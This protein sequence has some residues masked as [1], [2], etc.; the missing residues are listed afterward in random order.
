MKV[1]STFCRATGLE[2][3]HLLRF[4][5]IPRTLINRYDFKKL[6]PLWVRVDL[7]VMAMKV[8]S[9]FR[10]A[11]GLEPHHL[12]RFSFIP[13]TLIH[14][15]ILKKLL[16]LRVRVDLGVIAMK[17]C[18]ILP[19]LPKLQ[20]WSFTI[21]C[22]FVSYNRTLIADILTPQQRCCCQRIHQYQQTEL[23]HK[24]YSKSNSS[25]W[26]RKRCPFVVSDFINN[27]T[28]LRLIR[29]I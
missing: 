24:R 25:S 23:L 16:P 17:K 21:R 4:S 12:L 3:H 5:F 8:Y 22:S 28:K 13:R 27:L 7:G 1:Y 11:T 2:P 19:N 20:N 26:W 29:V 9:T 10:R 14:R 15:Y 6:Q 18:P